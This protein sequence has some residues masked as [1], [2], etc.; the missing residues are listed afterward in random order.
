MLSTR[1]HT[2]PGRTA[3]H[4]W[5]TTLLSS[6][7]VEG[8]SSMSWIQTFD[9]KHAHLGSCLDSELASPWPQNP[10]GPKRLPCH[11]LY[12]VGHC[13]GRTQSYIQTPLSLMVTFDSSG[14][15][16]TDA[17]S[18]L[19]PLRPVHSSPLGGLHPIT[20][21]H[22]MTNRP[23]F[24]SLGWMQASISISPCLRRTRTRPSLCYRENQDS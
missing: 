5:W 24:P 11:V 16:C 1:V 17:S 19:H 22:N 8:G 3:A 23:R 18:W 14:S 15:G 13:L 2:L 12:G 7:T 6:A 10:V 4:A 9:P 20:A 21:P